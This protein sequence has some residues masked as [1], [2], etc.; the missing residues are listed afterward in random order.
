MGRITEFIEYIN[1]KY[2]PETDLYTHL[3][4]IDRIK[5]IRKQHQKKIKGD[6]K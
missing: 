1:S 4:I 5:T 3:S 2:E 6:T